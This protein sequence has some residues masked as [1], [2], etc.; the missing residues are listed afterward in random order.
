MS[1][2]TQS[3]DC[4]TQS[5]PD[6]PDGYTRYIVISKKKPKKKKG[7]VHKEIKKNASMNDLIDDFNTL[8][9]EIIDVQNITKKIYFDCKGCFKGCIKTKIKTGDIN[10]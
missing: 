5:L 9:N 3:S 10:V 8:H 1:D 6:T 2:S 4:S 7:K